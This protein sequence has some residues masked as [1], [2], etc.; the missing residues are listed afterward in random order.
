MVD[1]IYSFLPFNFMRLDGETL[2]VNAGGDYLFLSEEDFGTF[3]KGEMPKNHYRYLD[4]KAKSFLY[5]T[6]PDFAVQL[7]ATQYRT[8][9][10]FLR[11]FTGLHMMVITLRCN[12]KCKYCQVSSEHADAKRFDMTTDT[13]SKCVDLIFKTPSPYIKIEF[14]GGEPLLNYDTM[15]FVVKYARKLNRRYKKDLEFVVCTNLTSITDEQ[16]SFCKNEGIYISTSLDGPNEIHDYNRV[17]EDGDGTYAKVIE[18]IEKAQGVIGRENVSALMT[19][20]KI[21]LGHFPEVVAEYISHGFNS[22]FFRPINPYGM[23]NKYKESLGYS[24]EE[25]LESYREGL[26][27]IIELN[28]K[29]KFIIEEYAR[30]V[31]RR[32]LTPFTTGFVDLQSPTGAAIGGVIY[33]YNG[34][35]FVAD[36]GRMLARKGDMKFFMGT[37]NEDYLRIFKGKTARETVESSCVECLPECCDCAFN[38]W[39]GAD[40]VRNYVTQGNLIG[41]R[42]TNDFCE[43][44][45]EIIKYLLRKY[46]A[47]DEDVKNVFWSWLT[48]IPISEIESFGKLE[49]VCKP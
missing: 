24:V 26:E 42:P 8:K 33:D 3:A 35:I 23:A 4:L 36:E 30:L 17:S 5:E 7:L 18:S 16:L 32:I 49:D 45:R 20:T 15:T 10:S 39:C 27:Y 44:N 25:F 38:M 28:L 9:K 37:V 34:N 31:L 14:Q 2:V 21:S 29:G 46:E 43:K 11:E 6:T 22:V 47:S 13:A 12:Q 1:K 19:A 41:Y 40:P 48:S